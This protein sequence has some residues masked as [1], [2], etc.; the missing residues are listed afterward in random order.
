MEQWQKKNVKF[1]S[2]A[3]SMLVL[4]IQRKLLKGFG[5]NNQMNE[6]IICIIL[7]ILLWDFTC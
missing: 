1:E 3:Y 7:K 5:I 4:D 2:C 6:I